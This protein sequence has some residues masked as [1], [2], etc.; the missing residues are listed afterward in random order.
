MDVSRDTVAPCIGSS[1]RLHPVARF[2]DVSVKRINRCWLYAGTCT[3]NSATKRPV[4]AR[5]ARPRVASKNAALRLFRL[6]AFAAENHP[7]LFSIRL[8]DSL[9]QYVFESNAELVA[10]FQP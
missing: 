6:Q 10:S 5:K 9:H 8:R 4:A 1:L 2:L 3:L 7:T